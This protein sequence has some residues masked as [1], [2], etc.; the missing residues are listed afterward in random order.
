[1]RNI[2][3]DTPFGVN[4]KKAVCSSFPTSCHAVISFLLRRIVAVGN[5]LLCWRRMYDY[6][7]HMRGGWA[8]AT[9]LASRVPHLGAINQR[10]IA[11]VP[12][13]PDTANG[14]DSTPR[15]NP[16][17]AAGTAP[18]SPRTNRLSHC[19]VHDARL[20]SL[21]SPAWNTHVHCASLVRGQ[22]LGNDRTARGWGIPPVTPAMTR[23][24]GG[25]RFDAMPMK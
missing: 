15:C 13:T 17:G 3:W 22:V 21:T 19:S 25:S 24:Q 4:P 8:R 18:R 2:I 10:G 23:E 20:P 7:T 1:M 5:Y 14:D 9:N 11:E 16:V 6:L 12:C